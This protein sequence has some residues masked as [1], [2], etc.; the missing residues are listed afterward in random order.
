MPDESEID[1]KRSIGEVA[2]ELGVKTHVIRFWEENFPQVKPEIGP[3]GRRYY[4]NQQFQILEKIKKFLYEDGYTIAG[5][6]K[7]LK[8]HG[9]EQKDRE[10][11]DLHIILSD[12]HK[13]HAKPLSSQDLI[14]LEDFIGPEIEFKKGTAIDLTA[15]IREFASIK[16]SA[17][18][19]DI[20]QEIAEKLKNIRINLE[21]LRLLKVDLT[22]VPDE[23][24]L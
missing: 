4:R 5:L 17:I 7:L 10:E 14:E 2:K 21:K 22:A 8:K 12:L 15:P 6:Q 1:R 3:G 23:E 16:I 20:K 19:A 9:E 13:K 24:N 18:D 11:E